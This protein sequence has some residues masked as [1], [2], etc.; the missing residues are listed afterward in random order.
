MVDNWARSKNWAEVYDPKTGK[1]NS[2][3]S[4]IQIRDKLMHASAVIDG[5]VYA[6][7]DRNGVCYEVKSGNWE[8]VDSDLDNGWRGR[9]CVIDGVLFCYDYL[10]NIRGYNVK[11]GTWK[12]HGRTMWR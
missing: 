10:G 8:T 5:K 1:W 2:V 3:P 6:M 4:P 9:A 11:E 12:G 7:A